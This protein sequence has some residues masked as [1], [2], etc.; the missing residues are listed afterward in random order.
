MNDFYGFE[1]GSHPRRGGFWKYTAVALVFLLI[2]ALGMYYIPGIG[3]TIR[4]TG[5]QDIGITLH[6]K[7]VPE[8][9]IDE[10]E[11][12]PDPIPA[13]GAKGDLFIKS[14]NPVIE[15]AEKVGP[16]IVGITN[17]SIITQ[18][19]PF[20]GGTTEREREGYGSG[21]I[22]SEDGYI[23]TNNHVIDNASE[24][25]V[26]LK[27]GKEVK[28]TLIGSDS[29]TDVAVIKIDEPDLTVAKI[30]DSEKVRQ[31]ELAIA[32]GNPLGH[33]LAGTVTV[34]VISAVDRE[35]NFGQHQFTMIQTDAAINPGNSGGA[36]VNSNG[37]IIGMNTLKTYA[38]GLG[39]AIPTNVFVPLA[40]ELIKSGSIQRPGIGVIIRE[41]T[42]ELRETYGYPK[43]VGIIEIA[44]NGAADTAGLLPKDIIIGV[45]DSTI[46]DIEELRKGINKHK[47]G[48][49]IEFT[50]W[51]NG[52]TFIAPIK[53][54][55]LQG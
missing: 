30:G 33:T 18:T 15:I 52:K 20:W 23:V 6:D 40:E 39:F 36:L 51:R 46:E 5:G 49:I 45:E 38:E 10:P 4:D 1:E 3:K 25:V 22:I 53:L 17:K 32:I 29:I 14:D 13:L 11:S 8:K 7:A 44:P 41:I 16:A 26:I 35:I 55:Q 24:L 50:I 48:D 28:A 47:V 21:I 34:G 2:G 12:N 9:D 43:G 42:D 19:D 54:Q 27:G 31:G 37:E